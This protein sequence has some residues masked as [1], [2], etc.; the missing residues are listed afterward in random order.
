[1][2]T[3]SKNSF[4]TLRYTAADTDGN[5]VDEGDVPL[6]Y[7]HGGY[8]GV[9]QPIEDA[10]E[11]KQVGD[12][13]T[14]KLQPEDAF[15]EYDPELL[16]VV[17]V[18]DLPRPLAVGMQLEGTVDEDGEEKRTFAT[19]T[20]IDGDK[21]VLDCNHPLAGTALVFNCEVVDVRPATAEELA[22]AQGES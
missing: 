9:F 11:G 3:I 8:E 15:G 6:K 16:D 22:A 10:L 20:D 13:V 12:S 1:M 4:V 7:V 14:V 21:A 17:P 5:L 18:A 2:D 19:V